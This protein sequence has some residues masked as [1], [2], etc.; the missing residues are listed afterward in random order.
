MRVKFKKGW[1]SMNKDGTWIWW[2]SKPVIE[3]D[4]WVNPNF[5]NYTG[6]YPQAI[7]Y[8]VMPKAKDWKK[9]LQEVGD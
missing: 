5:T 8:L 3:K 2:S 7:V 9:S 6:I 1:V 4:E